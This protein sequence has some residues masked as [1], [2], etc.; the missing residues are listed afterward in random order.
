[1]K[2]VAIG[3][4]KAQLSDM[5]YTVLSFLIGE[6]VPFDSHTNS[7]GSEHNYL[8][9]LHLRTWRLWDDVLRKLLRIEPLVN[10]DSFLFCLKQCR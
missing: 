9:N 7:S 5:A 1:M 8:S 10:D 2:G 6:D 4:K 3:M